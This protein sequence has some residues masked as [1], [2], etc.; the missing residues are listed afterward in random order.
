MNSFVNYVKDQVTNKI[1]HFKYFSVTLIK[2]KINTSK[3]LTLL[4]VF[5]LQTKGKGG[6]FI[7][8]SKQQT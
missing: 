6:S 3:Q 2:I 5:D 8:V 7:A 1:L 4:L